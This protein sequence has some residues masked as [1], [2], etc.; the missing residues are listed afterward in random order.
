MAYGSR[1]PI[2]VPDDELPMWTAGEKY[3]ADQ[4]T[5]ISE[6]VRRSLREKLEAEGV[7]VEMPKVRDD[8]ESR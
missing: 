4:G 8:N 3:A 7:A 6:L 5:S 1:K 2:Y